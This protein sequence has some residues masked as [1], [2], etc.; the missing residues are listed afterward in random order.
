MMR[1]LEEFNSKVYDI[2]YKEGGYN[3]IYFKHYKDTPYY[4]TWKEAIRKL[5]FLNRNISI[6]DI[7][8]GVGQFANMLFDYG[9]TNYKG[10][11]YSQEA[12]NMAQQT[13]TEHKSKFQCGDAL[14]H[15]IFEENY[16]LVI[17]FEILEHVNAD[18]K[19]MQRISKNSKVLFSVPN[20]PSKYHVRYF[21]N[22]KEV[23]NRYKPYIK[24]LDI[25]VIHLNK[26]SVLYLVCGI[27]K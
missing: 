21:E 16:N 20:F 3:G 25:Q 10:L 6:I 13:N 26:K 5:I 18:I 23:V 12:I 22:K 27:K 17:L 11:D 19:L 7:G 9:F 24:I 4:G 15:S 2:S 8:C 1:E 14:I